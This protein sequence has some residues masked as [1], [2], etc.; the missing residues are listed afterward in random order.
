MAYAMWSG[1]P[2]CGRADGVMMC[3][4]NPHREAYFKAQNPSRAHQVWIPH[5]DTDLFDDQEMAPRP[6]Q[7]DIDV[8][9]VARLD[10][11][12]NLDMLAEAAKHLRQ[13]SPDRRLRVVLNTGEGVDLNWTRINA[14]EQNE[15]RRINTILGNTPDY[16]YIEPERQ[17]SLSSLYNRARCVVMCALCEGKNRSIHEAMS[18]N[19]PVVTF[20]AFNQYARHNTL[21]FPSNAGLL[22]PEFTGASLADTIA[23]VLE[24]PLSFTPRESIL[25]VSGRR[26]TL[27]ACLDAFPYYAQNLPGYSHGQH[28]TNSWLDVSMQMLYQRSLSQHLYGFGRTEGAPAVWHKGLEEIERS[29]VRYTSL[30]KLKAVAAP[31]KGNG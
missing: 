11:I 7:K 19:I 29:L 28:L 3:Y 6:V 10:G 13:R 15:L 24:Q 21:P 17:K 14:H 8:L 26:T 9:C 27:N 30:V 31:E 12:K 22:A 2:R 16:I 18:C 4:D 23:K 5:D 1:V 25:K 20:E